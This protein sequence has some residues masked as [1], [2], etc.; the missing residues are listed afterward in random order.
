LTLIVVTT[1]SA[2]APSDNAA[3][4]CR[5][6]VNFSYSFIAGIIANRLLIRLL[7]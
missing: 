5:T 2:I 7:D 3:A 4:A 1:R 6:Q